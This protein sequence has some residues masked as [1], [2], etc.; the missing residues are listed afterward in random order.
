MISAISTLPLLQK[1]AVS[2]AYVGPRYERI[3]EAGYWFIVDKMKN[4]T[5]LTISDINHDGCISSGVIDAYSSELP[6]LRLLKVE[7][8]DEFLT[9]HLD[10][11]RKK[12]PNITVEDW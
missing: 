2:N 1:L 8:C 4:L 3:T 6:K 10:F 11:V 12:R 7:D 5:A 9:K